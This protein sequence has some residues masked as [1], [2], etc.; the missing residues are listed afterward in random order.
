MTHGT[1]PLEFRRG[2]SQATDPFV[3]S[4]RVTVTFTYRECLQEF[5]DANPAMRQ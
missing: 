5:Y 2:D 3:G 1:I 4:A